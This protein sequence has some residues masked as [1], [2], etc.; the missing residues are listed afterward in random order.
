LTVGSALFLVPAISPAQTSA[1]AK[2]PSS[3]SG[4]KGTAKAASASSS[5]SHSKTAASSLHKT[6]SK[7]KK[8]SRAN[9]RKRGQQKIDPQRAREIQEA[10]VREHYLS[11]EPS[12]VWD[13]ASE[14]AM[15][16]YQADNGWQD[17]STPDSRALIKLGLGPDRAHLLNP[18]SAMTAT[19]AT[20]PSR[21]DPAGTAPAAK[22]AV[23][24]AP[25]S[26]G[27]ASPASADP[28]ATPTNPG[29]Q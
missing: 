28:A 4:A 16:R 14:N 18:D 26:P 24:D 13:D 21:S 22:P 5:H 27:A 1:P 11:G 10:L 17:K 12:G 2:K 9:W 3:D 8:T 20:Q 6:S 29:P 23:G 19:S 7:R 15:R 25:T